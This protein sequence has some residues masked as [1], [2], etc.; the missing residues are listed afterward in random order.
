MKIVKIIIKNYK[1]IKNIEFEPNAKLNVF[2]GENSVGKSNIFNA[3]EWLLGPVYPSFNNFSKEDYYKGN[4][5]LPVKVIIYFDD[6]NSLAMESNWL[7]KY[8]KEKSG[9]HLNTY[10]YV[11]DDVRQKYVSAFLGIDRKISDNPATNRWTILGRLLQE[12]N[13]CFVQE[14]IYDE[15]TGERVL[16]SEK[17]TAAMNAI[18]DEFLFSVKDS[19]GNKI[20]QQFQTILQ[21]ETARQLNRDP[22]EF[23]LDLNIYDPWNFYRTLQVIV[24]EKDINMTFRASELGMG[25]QASL[26]IAILKGYSKLKLK[27]NTPIFI[28]EPEL[29]LHPQGR[30]NFYNILRELAENGTQIFLTTHSTEFIDLYHFDEIHIIRKSAQLGT[31]IRNAVPQKFVN[32]LF[33]R[34]NINSTAEELMSIYANA[35]EN[36][37]DSQ[38]SSEAIFA[39]KIILVEGESE[40]LI[41]PYFFKLLDFDPIL[42]GITIVRCGGKSELDRFYR[43]YSEFGIPCYIIFDGDFQNNTNPKKREDTIKKNKNILTIFNVS[44]EFPDNNVHNNYLGFKYRLEE[45]L[46]I[47]TVGEGVKAISLYKRVKSIIVKKDDVPNWV[48]LVIQKVSILPLE[49]KS[50]LKS[51]SVDKDLEFSIDFSDIPF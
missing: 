6:G 15:K 34:Q 19:N 16:K 50:I 40:V 10:D 42:N 46:N 4:T 20:M 8:G 45:N 30:R 11:T 2:V 31:Y 41:L 3:L 25:V 38:K 9:L 47:G 43:L 22:S 7:D 26:T 14:E 13:T 49:A 12:I 21:E 51:K 28:D 37:G 1:S 17:F 29:F 44:D 39:R 33:A 5:M 24:S 36:T 32:D 23:S 35:F 18:R 48:N 27:N